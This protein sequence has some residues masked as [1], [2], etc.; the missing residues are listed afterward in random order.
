MGVGTFIDVFSF[1][2]THGYGVLLLGTL[3]EG[4]VV[5]AAGAF[6]ASLGLFNLFIVLLISFAGDLIGDSIYFYIG[7][8]GGKPIVEKHGH[9]IGLD[10]KRI[11]HTEFLL[12]KHFLKTL[13]VLKLTPL[14][15]PPGLMIIGA[16]KIS[17]KKFLLNSL[18]V[19]IPASI[20]FALLGYYLGLAFDSFFKYFKMAQEFFLVIII[21]VIIIAFLVEKNVFGKIA[22]KLENI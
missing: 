22:R 8:F 21:L 1:I 20:T 16:S 12:K 13:I 9:K 11:K 19:I 18:I 6:S 10:K 4:P 7:R 14:L 17:F 15:A 2:Q 3:I 5:T